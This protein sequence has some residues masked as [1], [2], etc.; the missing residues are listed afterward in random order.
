LGL[1]FSI[2]WLKDMCINNVI[3]ELSS[4]KVVDSY[5]GN[6]RDEYDF[7]AIIRECRR[8]FSTFFYTSLPSFQLLIEMHDCIEI[9]LIIK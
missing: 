7:G 8:T 6:R 9:L 2:R 4:K 1:L 5:H 3:F